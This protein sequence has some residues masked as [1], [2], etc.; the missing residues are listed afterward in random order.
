M[1]LTLVP[2]LTLRDT[3]AK[4]FRWVNSQFS[5]GRMGFLSS[6]EG[7]TGCASVVLSPASRDDTRPTWFVDVSGRCVHELLP[8]ADHGPSDEVLST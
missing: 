6:A 2:C 4:E 1:L 3:T 5:N 8:V 7:D